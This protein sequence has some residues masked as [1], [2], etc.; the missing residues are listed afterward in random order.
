MFSQKSFVFQYSYFKQDLQVS[1]A[2]FQLTKS[3]IYVSVLGYK[4]GS[5]FQSHYEA[6]KSYFLQCYSNWKEIP[7]VRS[8]INVIERCD[9]FFL[10]MMLWYSVN[11]IIFSIYL[12]WLDTSSIGA[13]SLLYNLIAI[14]SCYYLQQKAKITSNYTFL[15]LLLN[16]QT[17]LLTSLFCI[18]K[19]EN[20]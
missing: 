3:E 2:I 16:S 4:R 6:W 14:I 20:S 7:W 11:N 9:N 19:I 12:L 13:T 5:I 10:S 17:Y 15:K 18:F 1:W 8:K